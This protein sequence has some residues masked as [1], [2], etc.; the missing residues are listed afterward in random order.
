[1]LLDLKRCVQLLLTGVQVNAK[2][3]ECFGEVNVEQ[4][5]ENNTNELLE[6][7]YMFPLSSADSITG[8]SISIDGKRNLIGV[9]KSKYTAKQE[10]RSAV[11][12]K[13]VA[14]YLEKQYNGTYQVRVGNIEPGSQIKV[15]FTYITYLEMRDG[16]YVFA[17]PTNI[18]PKYEPSILQIKRDL[19]YGYFSDQPAHSNDK[20]NFYKLNLDLT[21]ESRGIIEKL[22]SFTHPNNCVFEGTE[23]SKHLLIEL[24][25]LQGDFNLAMTTRTQTYPVVYRFQDISNTYLMLVHKIADKDIEEPHDT[26]YIFLV[27]RSGSMGGDKM[28][29]T[30]EALELFLRSLPAEKSYFNVV[31][32]GSNYKYLYPKCLEY[33]DSNLQNAL[34]EIKS[35]RA[36]MGGT[37]LYNV[38]NNL[39]NENTGRRRCYFL[40]TDG[41][42][43][44]SDRIAKSITTLKKQG[45]R[46][47]AMGVGSDAE[48]NLIEQV[49]SAGHGRH[50]MVIDTDNL[51]NAVIQLL[52]DCSKEYYYDLKFSL[53]SDSLFSNDGKE[54]NLEDLPDSVVSKAN[55]LIHNRQFVVVFRISNIDASLLNTLKLSSTRGSSKNT[56]TQSMDLNSPATDSELVAQLYG[57]YLLEKLESQLNYL[58]SEEQ[59]NK[60][61]D[62]SIRYGL[63]S[64]YT[65]FL[66]VDQQQVVTKELETKERQVPNYNSIQRTND[67]DDVL[68]MDNIYGNEVCRGDSSVPEYIMSMDAK[69]ASIVFESAR[70][71]S[72]NILSNFGSS[73]SKGITSVANSFSGMFTKNGS[74]VEEKYAPDDDDDEEDMCGDDI[75]GDYRPTVIDADKLVATKVKVIEFQNMNGS[76]NACKDLLQL[77][78]LSG[79]QLKELATKY[80]ISDHVALHI[81]LVKYFRLRNNPSEKLILKKL[82]NY[83]LSLLNNDTSRLDTYVNSI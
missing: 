8:F 49:S 79:E 15:K 64:K 34:A 11:E 69:S 10:Y 30:C 77:L 13:Q 7:V 52:D 70:I 47:F 32:F 6:V 80:S 28:T 18:A 5:Y 2:L 17:L 40:L 41:Q 56:F 58:S 50:Y 51:S 45:D 36:D 43:S 21:W 19:G 44:D 46:F 82:T 48:R 20:E 63:L 38:I 26:E 39:L 53:L 9:L 78:N 29:K 12:N 62:T 31:S 59:I 54:L 42:V 22:E 35:F 57:K 81:F 75:F 14:C 4:T 66:V 55:Y 23:T 1:M 68:L 76:F 33:N 24:S 3:L 27:D 61:V 83:V 73:L 16:K 72:K 71:P 65:A 60:V 25:P 67:L 74:Q 37:E